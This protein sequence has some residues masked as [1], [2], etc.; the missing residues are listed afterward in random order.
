MADHRHDAEVAAYGECMTCA[1]RGHAE[2]RRARDAAIAAAGAGA[3]EAW[4]G[5]ARRVVRQLAAA[6]REFTS[7][8]VWRVLPQ[9]P[10]PRAL[11]AVMTWAVDQ[12]LVVPTDRTVPSTRP[13]CHAR[14]VRVWAPQAAALPLG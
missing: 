14:P 13:E 8:D 12:Q 6:G 7:D 5:N 10:E 3:P 4:V 11:G 2:A 1:R 9:P